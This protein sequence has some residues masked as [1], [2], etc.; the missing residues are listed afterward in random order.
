M[1]KEGLAE[2][3]K[4]QESDIGFVMG[5]N[6]KLKTRVFEL[7]NGSYADLSELAQAMGISIAQACRVRQGKRHISEKFIIGAVK[8]FPGYKLSDLFYVVRRPE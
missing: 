7:S 5:L 4:R 8:A 6:M 2:P 1:K 3:E